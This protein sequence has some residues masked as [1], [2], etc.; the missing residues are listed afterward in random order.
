MDIPTFCRIWEC[1]L[2]GWDR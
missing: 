2:A 1:C